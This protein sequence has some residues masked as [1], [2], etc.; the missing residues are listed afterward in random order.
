MLVAAT[1]QTPEADRFADR[2]LCRL[3]SRRQK[4][5]A[6]RP[7][8]PFHQPRLKRVAEEGERHDGTG[9][10]AIRILAEDNLRLLRMESQPTRREACFELSA[11]RLGLALGPTM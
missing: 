4:R 1:L 10:G 8:R 11:Q 6:I 2:L 3:T 7:V 9:A 5:H